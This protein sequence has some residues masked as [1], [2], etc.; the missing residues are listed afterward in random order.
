MT[1]GSQRAET[2]PPLGMLRWQEEPDMGETEVANV[3]TDL[4][5]HRNRSHCWETAREG[6]LESA[7]S[8]V[9]VDSCIDGEG[10]GPTDSSEIPAS[11]GSML[12]GPKKALVRWVGSG[13]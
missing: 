9:G 5:R 4:S 12:E 8:G 10:Q 3:E 2:G 6:V 13:E 7:P 11:C 1:K